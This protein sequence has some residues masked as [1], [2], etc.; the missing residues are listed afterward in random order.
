MNDLASEPP[1]D[2]TNLVDFQRAAWRLG[3]DMDDYLA[4]AEVFL[5]D[6]EQTRARLVAAGSAERRH[7]VA[8][9]HELANSFGVV[10]ADRAERLAR[11]VERGLRDGENLDVAA[12]AAT[13]MRELAGVEAMLRGFVA[14]ARRGAVRPAQPGGGDGADG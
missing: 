2:V 1:H 14:G 7:L 8:V 10:G 11:A 4:V 5:E 6:A 3:G 9:S 13:L 12:S